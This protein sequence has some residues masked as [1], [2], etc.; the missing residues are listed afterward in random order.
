MQTPALDSRRL[1]P[2]PKGRLTPDAVFCCLIAAVVLGLK[3]VF[4]DPTGPVLFFDELLYRLGAEALTG[5]D[6]YPSGQYP[7]LYPALLAPAL[8]AGLGYEGIFLTNVIATTSLIPA[9]WLLAKA[10]G[11]RWGWPAAL[12]VSLLPLHWVYPTQVL[13]E[14]L[15]V[16]LFTWVTWY[17]I[18]AK[19]GCAPTWFAFGGCLGG[20]LLT[21]Y[22]LLPTIPLLLAFWLHGLWSK[23]T[24]AT[25]RASTLLPPLALSLLGVATAIT[26]WLV[27]ANTQNIGL[28]EAFGSNVVTF[29]PS[30]LVSHA[31]IVMWGVAYL[32]VVVLLAAPFIPHFAE[33]ALH[34]LSSPM[35]LMRESPLVR[36]FILVALLL[37]GYWLICVRHSAFGVGKNPIPLR[38]VV[39]YFMHITPLIMTLGLAV[40]IK[41][42]GRPDWRMMTALSAMSGFLVLAAHGVLYKN[43]IWDFPQWFARIPLYSLD[44]RGYD[45]TLVLYSLVALLLMR[46]LAAIRPAL[47]KAWLACLF[48]I[49]AAA[50]AHTF[51]VARKITTI[52]PIHPRILAPLVI[53]A[54]QAN[55]RAIIITELPKVPPRVMQQALRFWGA[56]PEKFRVTSGAKQMSFPSGTVIYRITDKVRSA[57]PIIRYTFGSSTGY[58]YEESTAG[59]TYP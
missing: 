42:I 11:L 10:V 29:K 58:V 38:V 54:T 35:Q 28:A 18:R 22:L 45:S 26:V 53:K 41:P 49:I 31:S 43:A 17:A 50:G 51:E 46:P 23:S 21:K 39:R 20:L 55:G 7:F 40:A 34:I 8:A 52:D 44:I 30:N 32:C 16:P 56:D 27:Y 37:A 12:L 36:L 24:N 48:T 47:N 1:A 25:A 19:Q 33:T 14:N 57:Q 15:S 2:T 13:S 59:A 5:P 9:A 4:L 3:L 6:R